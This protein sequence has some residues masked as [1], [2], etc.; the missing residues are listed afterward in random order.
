MGSR[1]LNLVWGPARRL[2][3][4][5]GQS[6]K[7]MIACAKFGRRAGS[8]NVAR[9]PQ[10]RRGRGPARSGSTQSCGHLLAVPLW[11]LYALHAR[12]KG[13][14]VMA[15]CHGGNRFS[16]GGMLKTA[17]RTWGSM[18]PI[19]LVASIGNSSVPLSRRFES[20]L[21]ASTPLSSN[22][23]FENRS[24]PVNRRLGLRRDAS[25]RTHL[26]QDRQG[27]QLDNGKAVCL[28]LLISADRT[29]RVNTYLCN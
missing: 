8:P 24:R 11:R 5:H 2:H 20:S 9:L 23:P 13:A 28:E 21:Q 6:I 29:P 17:D 1:D 16:Q 4:S 27:P 15:P 3:R 19:P 26:W 12:L 18:E 22:P 14:D 7:R 10:R 25:H